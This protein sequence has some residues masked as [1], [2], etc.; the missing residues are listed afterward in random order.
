MAES[1][2]KPTSDRKQLTASGAEVVFLLFLVA[3]GMGLCIWAD[4]AFSL[5]YKEPTEQEFFGTAGIKEKQEKL[6]RLEDAIKEAE[7]QLD[8][9]ALDR[10]K[11]SATLKSI[12][13]LH[14]EIGKPRQGTAATI[15]AEVDK[16]Y[17]SARM[18]QLGADEYASMLNSLITTLRKEAQE[19]AQTLEPEKQAATKEYTWRRRVYLLEKFAVSFLLPLP[20]VLLALFA[21]A[22]LFN[23]IAKRQVWISHGKLPAL[24]VLCALLVLLAYQAFEIAGA[25]FIAII[26]FLIVLR[27][28]NWTP[29][30]GEKEAERQ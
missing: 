19:T 5:F 11:Q 21:G 29:T 24:L 27:K 17:E 16:S 13:K 26:L 18:Q 25:V 20:V 10:L 22:G 7:K 4:R 1:P 28:I 23:R 8:T 9:V 6:T 30:V 15:P 14:P 3:F 2:A 12:E